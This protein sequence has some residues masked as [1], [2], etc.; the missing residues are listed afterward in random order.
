MSDFMTKD[1]G[2]RE[3][4]ATGMVRDTE[5][6]KPRFDLMYPLELPYEAQFITRYGLLLARGAEK[7][8]DRN[9]ESGYDPAAHAR[10][11]SS[12]MRHMVQWISGMRDEDHA[13]AVLFNLQ[14]AEYHEFLMPDP[15]AVLARV[16]AA[17]L[18]AWPQT[19]LAGAMRP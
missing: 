13:A 18:G 16:Q 11:K 2:Q 17:E 5:A 6:G 3:Q 15:S 4:Y 1:S 19:F 9:W 10:A 14:Q 8:G 7:Y 12:G